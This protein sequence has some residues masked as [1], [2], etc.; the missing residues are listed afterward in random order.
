VFDQ[1][2]CELTVVETHHVTMAWWEKIGKRG[3]A[4]G[5]RGTM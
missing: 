5:R 4:A 1:L 3:M 2:R